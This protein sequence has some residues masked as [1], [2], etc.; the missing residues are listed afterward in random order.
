MKVVWRLERAT[1]R[2]VYE[3]LREGRSLAYTTVMTMM[4]ILERKGHLVRHKEG[5]AYV[6]EPARPRNQV[7][8]RMVQE[9]V[10]RVFNGAPEPLVLNLLQEKKL[11]A[12][13]LA[14]LVQALEEESE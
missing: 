3:V 1:V 5:R 10:D 12:D 4:S 7:I 11:S 2:E 6:Y 8:S 9:F 14:E 13:D